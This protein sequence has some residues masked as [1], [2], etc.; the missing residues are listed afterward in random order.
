MKIND[1]KMKIGNLLLVAVG[2]SFSISSFSQDHFEK[3]YSNPD[4]FFSYSMCRA[5]EDEFI[6]G[7]GNWAETWGMIKVNVNGEMIW[8][9][10][11]SMESVLPLPYLDNINEDNILIVQYSEF[12]TA[13]ALRVMKMNAQGEFFWANDY[14]RVSH[15]GVSSIQTSD[16]NIYITSDGAPI[17]VLKLSDDGEWLWTRRISGSGGGTIHGYD[18]ETKIIETHDNKLIVVGATRDSEILENN[19][20]IFEL[21]FNGNLIWGKILGGDNVDQFRSV[22]ETAD[23]SYIA[24]GFTQS[25]GT[26]GQDYFLVKFDSAGNIIWA[27]TYGTYESE[28]CYDIVGLDGGDFLL[29]GRYGNSPG[30][31]KGHLARIDADGN[32]IWSVGTNDKI[33]F[34]DVSVADMNRIA[35]TGTY[36]DSLE[37]SH[38][39]LVMTDSSGFLC[40]SLPYYLEVNSV[41]PEVSTYIVMNDFMDT[42]IQVPVVVD[43]LDVE[44][45]TICYTTFQNE[46]PAV[47]AAGLVIFPNPFSTSATITLPDNHVYPLDVLIYSSTGALIQKIPNLGPGPLEIKRD[48]LASGLYFIQVRNPK[49][50]VATG[51]AFI[52]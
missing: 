38:S 47:S 26:G 18:D 13:M 40:E 31:S 34:R 8:A 33:S 45:S 52:L 11:F 30:E 3:H 48:D 1:L 42:T 21:D 6:I 12:G 25:M 4:G 51:K 28:S 37:I 2:L 14:L 27:R 16:G 22:A 29:S 39:I 49:G 43:N 5:T 50:I 15:W 9:K 10:Q 35:I 46:I 20:F 36:V 24:A 32:L 23:H 41:E 7:V 19:A 17:N 44:V